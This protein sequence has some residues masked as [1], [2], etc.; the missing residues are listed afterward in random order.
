MDLRAIIT[1]LLRI[2]KVAM[3]PKLFAEDPRIIRAFE[4][5]AELDGPGSS[6]RVPNVPASPAARLAEFRAVE[7]SRDGLSFIT[8]L[9]WDLVDALS[10]AQK[11]VLP[12]DPSAAVNL[13]IREWLTSA[14]FL[15]PAALGD[16]H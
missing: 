1:D 14:G 7:E 12:G 5:L 16:T 13:V 11:T 8:D 4:A 15:L 2:A 10:E 6:V 3:P 9:P